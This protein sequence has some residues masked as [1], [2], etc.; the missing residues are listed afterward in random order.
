[1][2]PERT[3]I[4]LMHG[5][6]RNVLDLRLAVDPAP[7]WGGGGEEPSYVPGSLDQLLQKMLVCQIP[8][9]GF[10]FGSHFCKGLFPVFEKPVILTTKAF[11]S[12]KRSMHVT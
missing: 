10:G 7:L 4:C 1:M 8:I 2:L 11:F 3:F 9:G 5:T 6:A 12:Y